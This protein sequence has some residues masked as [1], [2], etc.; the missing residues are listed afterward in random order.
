MKHRI[1]HFRH[2]RIYQI[3]LLLLCSILLASN[4]VYAKSKA[5]VETILAHFPQEWPAMPEISSESAIVI[6]RDSSTILYAKNATRS[7]YPASTT[8]LMTAY[9][10]LANASMDETVTFSKNSIYS[11]IPGSSHIGMKIGESLSVRDCLY[12]LLLPSANEVGT[13]LA[14]HVSGSVN[15]FVETMNTTAAELGCINT[16]FANANGLQDPAHMTCAY[17]LALIMNACLGYSEFISISSRTAYFRTADELLPRDIPMGTTNQLI[18]KDSEF[19]TPYVICGKTGWTE[20]AGR[21]LVTYAEKDGRHL[22]CVVMNS[23]APNQYK[24]TIN[25]LNYG[26]LNFDTIHVSDQDDS[27]NASALSSG[28]PIR[29]PEY[30]ETVLALDTSACI[31]LPINVSLDAV[32]RRPVSFDENTRGISY[33]LHGYPLGQ[34]AVVNQVQEDTADLF[35]PQQDSIRNHLHT[36]ALVTIPVWLSLALAAVLLLIAA[37][38]YF[39]IRVLRSKNSS[40][41]QDSESEHRYHLL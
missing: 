33:E 17:D 31:T 16:H 24:D 15:A 40:Q 7:M 36:T 30:E 38:V 9:L 32:T 28:S 12:G 4:P 19:Y 18:K 34:A 14:E 35:A 5:Q 3:A 37:V 13:A 41:E 29:I 20:E 8:K 22:I 21:C 10:T 39:L 23:E 26:F 25:L 6:D 27:L 2:F 1:H 11:L